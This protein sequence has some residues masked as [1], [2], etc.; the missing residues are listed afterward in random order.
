V[1]SVNIEE[2]QAHL[3]QIIVRLNPGERLLITQ[4]GKPVATLSRVSIKHW[5]CKAGSAKTTPHWMASDFDAPL[6]DFKEY[7]E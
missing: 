3:P 2:A 4:D 5:P 1:S 6:E 7:M